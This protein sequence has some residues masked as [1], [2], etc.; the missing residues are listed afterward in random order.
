MC[1]DPRGSVVTLTSF[2]ELVQQYDDPRGSFITLT[3]F[4]GLSYQ[5]DDPG[6]SFVTLTYFKARFE[7]KDHKTHIRFLMPF[8]QSA[9]KTFQTT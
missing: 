3:Y 4:K 9:F 2:K 5:Y 1:D 8:R 7:T 6:G